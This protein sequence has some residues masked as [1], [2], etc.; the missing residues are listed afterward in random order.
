M[1]IAAVSTSLGRVIGN[2]TLSV[3]G[4]DGDTNFQNETFIPLTI[5]SL[6]IVVFILIFFRVLDANVERKKIK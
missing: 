2:M 1:Y 5:L 3:A 6:V 4:R